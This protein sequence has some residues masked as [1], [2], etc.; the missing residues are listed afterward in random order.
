MQQVRRQRK[1]GRT[2]TQRHYGSAPGPAVIRRVWAIVTAEPDRN[3]RLIAIDL[4]LPYSSVY[5]ALRIL[6]DA[7]YIDY[8]DHQ[9]GQR[10]RILVPF[11]E[12]RHVSA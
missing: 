11:V 12:V 6:R 2:P 9:L 1:Y 4:H 5:A 8:A 10:R 3:G 7:G